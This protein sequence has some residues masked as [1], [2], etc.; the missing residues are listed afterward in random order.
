MDAPNI[1]IITQCL[2]SETIQM[3]PVLNGINGLEW[4]IKKYGPEWEIKKYGPAVPSAG[5]GPGFGRWVFEISNVGQNFF[6]VLKVHTCIPLLHVI[7][8]R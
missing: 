6:W 8:N 2:N 1:Q 4:E 3:E 5:V 7:E